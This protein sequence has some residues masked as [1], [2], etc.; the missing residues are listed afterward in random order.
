MW[1]DPV[2][3]LILLMQ[4]RSQELNKEIEEAC[5]KVNFI[6]L[7]AVLGLISHTMPEKWSPEINF[8]VSLSSI[9]GVES[10]SNFTSAVMGLC[11]SLAESDWEFVI[12][13]MKTNEKQSLK[14]SLHCCHLPSCFVFKLLQSFIMHMLRMWLYTKIVTD[15]LW[16][17]CV[18][19]GSL[20][21]KRTNSAALRFKKRRP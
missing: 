3:Y 10:C 15:H 14:N 4:V 5:M 1:C 19:E 20:K 11:G 18:F 8:L 21:K 7:N 9:C 12:T 16:Q 6:R 13:W 17:L 2:F